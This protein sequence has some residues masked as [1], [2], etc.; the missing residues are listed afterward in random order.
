MRIAVAVPILL[1]LPATVIEDSAGQITI[2]RGYWS[3]S[4][5]IADTGEVRLR[6]TV[7][8]AEVD[9]VFQ[10]DFEGAAGDL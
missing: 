2:L 1:A 6:Y 8:S 3:E 5:Y 4:T 10:D 7:E 9:T